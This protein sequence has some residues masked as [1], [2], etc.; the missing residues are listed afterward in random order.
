M[1]ITTK[2]LNDEEIEFIIKFEDED[3]DCS[4]ETKGY[5][6]AH[7]RYAELSKNLA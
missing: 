7:G 2:V 5:C 3:H 6:D 1:E 4:L